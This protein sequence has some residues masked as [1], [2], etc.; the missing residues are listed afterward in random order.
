MNSN[1]KTSQTE[2][3]FFNIC[4]KLLSVRA[5]FQVKI[6]AKHLIQNAFYKSES[7]RAFSERLNENNLNR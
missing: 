5:L 1:N 7:V 2:N 6:C 4:H 3:F